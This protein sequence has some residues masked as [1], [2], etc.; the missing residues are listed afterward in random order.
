[1]RVGG[2]ATGRGAFDTVGDFNPEGFHTR[3]G[4]AFNLGTFLGFLLF[5]GLPGFD[6]V[7]LIEFLVVLPVNQFY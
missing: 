7:R 6:V 5:L 2:G 3:G 4:A 1:L